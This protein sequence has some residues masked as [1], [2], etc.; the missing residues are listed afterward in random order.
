[1]ITKKRK[2]QLKAERDLTKLLY[3]ARTN[4]VVTHPL[5]PEEV[6]NVIDHYI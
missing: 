1:M 5:T 2:L 3:S 4:S 6:Q